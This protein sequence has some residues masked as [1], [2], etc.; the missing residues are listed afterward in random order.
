[1]EK[2]MFFGANNIIFE[3][4]KYLRKNMT[5]AEKLL[6]SNLKSRPLGFK[7]RRQHPMAFFIADFYCHRAKL[8]IELDGSIHNLEEVR[9]RDIERQRIIEELGIKVIRFT[10]K[11]VFQNLEVVLKEINDYLLQVI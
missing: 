10:N 9:I 5:E 6:W 3:N 11:Q 7:F 8:V 2:K 4:A 1:M